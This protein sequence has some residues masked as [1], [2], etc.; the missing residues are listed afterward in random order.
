MKSLAVLWQFH[1]NVQVL[2]DV[3]YLGKGTE[4]F[5]IEFFFCWLFPVKINIKISRKNCARVISRC[6]TWT[7]SLLRRMRCNFRALLLQRPMG[8]ILGPKCFFFHAMDRGQQAVPSSVTLTPIQSLHCS[9]KVD[10][11]QFIISKKLTY[12]CTICHEVHEI[13]N[14][15]IIVSLHDL[16]KWLTCHPPWGTCLSW[17]HALS[18]LKRYLICQHYIC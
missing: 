4:T 17:I 1:T 13:H 10:F 7:W 11:F 9:C 3:E 8:K 15:G 6:F 18:A 2:V 5:I 12:I 16:K 14:V